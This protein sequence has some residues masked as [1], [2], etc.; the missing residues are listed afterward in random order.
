MKF[1]IRDFE[2]GEMIAREPGMR[3]LEVIDGPDLCAFILRPKDLAAL[4]SLAL[5]VNSHE[6]LPIEAGEV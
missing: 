1:R 5:Q 3:V 4:N 6:P 2:S